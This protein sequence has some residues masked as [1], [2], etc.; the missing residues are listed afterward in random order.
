MVILQFRLSDKGLDVTLFDKIFKIG[1]LRLMGYT[2]LHTLYVSK[3]KVKSCK[4][5]C[6]NCSCKNNKSVSE[7]LKEKETELKIKQKL[8][9]D[10]GA[11]AS[12]I[13]KLKS[14]L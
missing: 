12:E 2:V 13:N 1:F 6:S 5:S 8:G 10:V 9:D 14:E 7:R 11:L 3:T 4:A